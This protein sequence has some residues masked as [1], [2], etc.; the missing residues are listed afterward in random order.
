MDFN[1][2]QELTARTENHTDLNEALKEYAFGIAG[3]SG[4][5]IDDIKKIVYHGHNPENFLVKEHIAQELGD[6]LWYLARIAAKFNVNLEDIAIGNIAKIRVRYPEG[7]ST[8]RSVN[9][10]E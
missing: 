3:E 1:E 9:R 4:E 2:Y 10:A 5:V 7:F 8:E 6:L